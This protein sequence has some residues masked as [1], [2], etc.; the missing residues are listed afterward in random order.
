VSLYLAVLRDVDPIE[1]EAISTLK[2][3]LARR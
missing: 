1:I 2:A 3:A